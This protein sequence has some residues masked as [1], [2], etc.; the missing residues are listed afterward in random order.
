[1]HKVYEHKV[2]GS[3]ISREVWYFYNMTVIYGLGYLGMEFIK[4]ALLLSFEAKMHGVLVGCHIV[5]LTY[6]EDNIGVFNVGIGDMDLLGS[7]RFLDYLHLITE[8]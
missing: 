5:T 2:N 1:M 6:V 4:N 8:Y 7:I 3:G